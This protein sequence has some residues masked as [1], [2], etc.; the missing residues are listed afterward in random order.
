MKKMVM[1]VVPR[2]GAEKLL[3]ALVNAGHTATFMESR[4]GMLRQSQLSLFTAVDSEELE[5]VL[6]IIRGSCS[7]EMIVESQNDAEM[8][9]FGQTSITSGV[10]GAV[11]F[12]W[13]IE[14]I[15]II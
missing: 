14:G 9:S 3:N 11:I 15:E 10:G 2:N 8:L 5:K 4:G 6:E 7:T 1:T 12:I 13:S